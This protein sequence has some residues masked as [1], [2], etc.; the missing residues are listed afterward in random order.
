MNDKLTDEKS[1]LDK[2]EEDVIKQLGAAFQKNQAL[3]PKTDFLV[4]DATRNELKKIA[5]EIL[6]QVAAGVQAQYDKEVKNVKNNPLA[7][8][9]K[10][11]KTS[12]YEELVNSLGGFLPNFSHPGDAKLDETKDYVKQ[13]GVL[14]FGLPEYRFFGL[15]SKQ[16]D[17]SN[18]SSMRLITD[19][20]FVRKVA[21]N[22]ISYVGTP[23]RG[24]TAS[25]RPETNTLVYSGGFPFYATVQSS[26]GSVL[27][28]SFFFAQFHRMMQSVTNIFTDGIMPNYLNN[29]YDNGQYGIYLR[30]EA[31]EGTNPNDFVKTLSLE[32]TKFG[33]QMDFNINLSA[34]QVITRIPGLDDVISA[35]IGIPISGYAGSAVDYLL[36]IVLDQVNEQQGTNYSIR[37]LDSPF[38]PITLYPNDIKT[39]IKEDPRGMYF[40]VRG[41]EL[42]DFTSRYIQAKILVTKFFMNAL[43]WGGNIVGGAYGYLNFDLDQFPGNLSSQEMKALLGTGSAQSRAIRGY[44]DN[45]PFKVLTR[46]QLPPAPDGR[47]AMRLNSLDAEAMLSKKNEFYPNGDLGRDIVIDRNKMYDNEMRTESVKTWRAYI[48]PFDKLHKLNTKNVWSSV[49]EWREVKGEEHVLPGADLD[50]RNITLGVGEKFYNMHARFDRVIDYFTGDVLLDHD[51][52]HP[53]DEVKGLK[54]VKS[55]DPEGQKTRKADFDIY[56]RPFTVYY[57][58]QMKLRD[59]SVIALRPTSVSVMQLNEDLLNEVNQSVGMLMKTFKSTWS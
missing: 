37:G 35:S 11:T 2:N 34:D 44:A 27:S 55:V 57:T 26:N 28:P 47:L 16:N 36:S 58:G 32:K 10:A 50:H 8:L 49:A 30:M 48:S 13:P 53:T 14:H 23:Y 17:Y 41:S 22:L 52:S 21:D 1:A 29:Q 9:Y 56:N 33:A 46:G 4:D 38:Y 15:G 7:P 59:G 40:L 20:S 19:K 25:Y 12:S 18:V 6:K 45:S 43:S 54:F 39:N 31:P 51:G 42:K 5:D 24:T 3:F